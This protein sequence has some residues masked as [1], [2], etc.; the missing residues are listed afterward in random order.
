MV[1]FCDSGPG[2]QL[3]DNL[4][5]DLAG[6]AVTIDVT[7]GPEHLDEGLAESSVDCSR[8][9]RDQGTVDIKEEQSRRWSSISPVGR[10]LGLQ[11]SR[12]IP[13]LQSALERAA[14]LASTAVSSASSNEAGRGYVEQQSLG[15]GDRFGTGTLQHFQ[16]QT[17]SGNA[18]KVVHPAPRCG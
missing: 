5:I 1:G 15:A 13:C 17:A 4:R 6:K 9:P 16:G 3:G 11:K 14:S 18:D 8:L 7:S 2:Q 12:D 10:R